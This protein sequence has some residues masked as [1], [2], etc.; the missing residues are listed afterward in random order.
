MKPCRATGNAPIAVPFPDFPT[1]VTSGS[2][3]NT[4][5]LSSAATYD[6]GFLSANGGTP[7]SAT[8]ALL[9]AIAYQNHR[10]IQMLLS[11]GADVNAANAAGFSTLILAAMRNDPATAWSGWA[12]ET[13]W[14]R[15]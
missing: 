4:L 12:G 9:N 15:T 11:R 3:S 7:Q 10:N 6:P 8:T 14:A 1:G 13:S 5:S 2:Y